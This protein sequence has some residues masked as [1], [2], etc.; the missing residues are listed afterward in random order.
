MGSA[1]NGP[2]EKWAKRVGGPRHGSLGELITAVFGRTEIHPCALR[3]RA[4]DK[5]PAAA[6]VMLRLRARYVSKAA[7]LT[8]PAQPVPVENRSPA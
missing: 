5:V 4:S 8:V 2:R 6:A 1:K 7:I 3:I